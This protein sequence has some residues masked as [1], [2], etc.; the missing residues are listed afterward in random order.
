MRSTFSHHLQPNHPGKM[1]QFGMNAGPRHK[2]IFQRAVSVVNRKKYSTE[3][4]SRK[5]LN[6]MGVFSFT[7]NKFLTHMPKEVVLQDLKELKEAG[8]PTPSTD[9]LAAGFG[10]WA[11][12]LLI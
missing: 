9:E 2:R 4:L 10:K 7:Y 12:N 5:D 3:E 8:L 6:C 1:V 11:F